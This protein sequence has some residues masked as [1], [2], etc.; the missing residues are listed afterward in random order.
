[1][2]PWGATDPYKESSAR[3]GQVGNLHKMTPLGKR[4]ALRCA[5]PAL[6]GAAPTCNAAA[7]LTRDSE[8]QA[9][10]DCLWASGASRAS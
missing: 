2:A 7:N 9:T 4:D 5:V 1:M 10:E 6:H 3:T 8:A